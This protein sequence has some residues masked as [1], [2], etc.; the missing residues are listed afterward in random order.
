MLLEAG[1][2]GL[3]TILS[4][5]LLDLSGMLGVSALAVTGLCVLPYRRQKIKRELNVR[6]Q[7]LRTKMHDTLTQHF[8]SELVASKERLQGTI[9][10]FRLYVES[11]SQKLERLSEALDRLAE[12]ANQLEQEINN[13]YP[14]TK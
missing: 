1:A 3:G 13:A 14:A 9:S 7:Q 11:E 2:V 4:T 12:Q 10:P 6:I 5:F 8:D